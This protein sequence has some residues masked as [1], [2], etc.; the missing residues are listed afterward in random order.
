MRILY[1][2]RTAAEDGQAVHIRALQAAFRELG[3]TVDEVA[4]VQQG[5]GGGQP[6]SGGGRSGTSGGSPGSAG[7][8][9]FR[10]G[11]VTNVPRWTRELLE[12]AYGFSARRR[13]ASRARAGRY[14]FLYERYAFGNLGGVLAA[15]DTGL[16]CVLE[17]NSPMVLELSRTRGLS[18]PRLAARV[19][20]Q[21]FEQADLVCAV[22]G[23]LARMVVELGA[24]PER[25][26]V[27]PNGVEL[28]RY[29]WSD[30]AGARAAARADL[31]LADDALVLG[32]VGYYRSWHRLELAVRALA[33]PELERV[34][35]CLVGEGPARAEIEAEAARCGV[36][37]RVRFAGRRSHERIPDLLPAFDI[38]LLPAINSYASPLK[39]HEYMAAGLACV[40]PDQP[41]LREVLVAGQSALL[42]APGNEDDLYGAIRELVADATLRERLG[43]C[44]RAEVLRR[45]LTWKGNARRVLAAVERLR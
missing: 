10:W 28:E 29:A 11:W 41:N 2:H 8:G 3:H 45:D 31:G 16:P 37:A 24:R 26:F 34:V 36:A 21:V 5:S 13:I 42:V 30:R 9:R 14:D 32:F 18:F 4:L 38:G 17:V 27:T 39:L 19:E 40:A 23:V 1:H 20:R 6:G 33:R 22:S 35:L 25:V 12:Y 15:R 43:A 44:A 7:G